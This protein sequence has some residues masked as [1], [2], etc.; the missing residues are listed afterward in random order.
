MSRRLRWDRPE[1]P[2]PKHPYRDSAIA[3]FALAVIVV[4]AAWATGGSIGRALVWG[5]AA[6]VVATAWSWWR[7]RER[8]AA[9][10]RRRP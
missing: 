5:V 7:W 10:R 1:P 3:Y 9:E 4:L 2:T 8:L 6:F